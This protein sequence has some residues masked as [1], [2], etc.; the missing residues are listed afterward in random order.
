MK[1]LT[2]KQKISQMFI[3][4]FDGND[5]FSPSNRDFVD[6]LKNG[7]GGVIFF[8]KNITSVEQIKRV[9]AEINELSLIKPFLSID[10][11]GGRVERTENIHNGKKYLSAKVVAAE[12]IEL[13]QKQSVCIASELV[14]YGINMNFA[15]VLD[16]DTNADNPIIAERAYSSFSDD[17]IKNGRV[18]VNSF[19]ANNII[20]VAKH[21]PGHGETTVDS[22]LVMPMLDLPLSVLENIHIKPF[23]A[24]IDVLP[25]IMVAH[26]HYL[27]FDNEKVPASI[28]KNVIKDY[29]RNKLCFD[30]LVISDDMVMGGI[31]DFSSIE[32]CKRGINAGVNM[33]IFRNSDKQTLAL[34]DEIEKMVK[35]GEIDERDIDKSVSLILRLKGEFSII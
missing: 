15:P 16:V 20:P 1:N 31:K 22:H 23:K 4:G 30:G 35:L 24:L 3:L 5:I 18:V 33:F 11:E 28:S 14:S 7:L 6:V 34:I 9:T 27:A 25:A 12:G 10:Q 2:L 21:F 8:T 17:V 13:V 32:A 19:V 29:L 26:V